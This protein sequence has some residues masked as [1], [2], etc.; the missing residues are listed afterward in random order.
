MK[1]VAPADLRLLSRSEFEKQVLAR[2]RGKCI[3]CEKAAIDAHHIME[4]KLF[5]DGGYYLANGAAVCDSH[6]WDCETTRL[7]VEEVRAKAGVTLVVLP[8]SFSLSQSYDKWGNTVRPDGLRE[9]GP[10]FTDTGC[11]KALAL[12]GY[13]GLFVP[14]GTP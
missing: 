1:T 6:H 4:R 8:P 3:F 11:H 7:S 5:E 14:P 10:L 9:P 13:L 2:S 12:G